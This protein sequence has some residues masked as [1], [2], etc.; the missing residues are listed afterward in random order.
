M[1]DYVVAHLRGQLTIH[2]YDAMTTS[3]VYLKFDYGAAGSM[4]IG[5]HPGKKHLAY[6]YNIRL[7][8]KARYTRRELGSTRHYYARADIDTA[9]QDVLQGRRRRILRTGGAAYALRM[10]ELRCQAAHSL[11]FWPR[12]QQVSQGP[13]NI[14]LRVEGFNTI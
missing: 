4:R 8:G 11:G 7:D 1:A 10:R 12:A 5:A 13:E 2:R 3:S 9:I 14:D 6:T